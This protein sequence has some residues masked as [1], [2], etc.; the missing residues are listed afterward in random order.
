MILVDGKSGKP[1]LI[2]ALRICATGQHLE[3]SV[4]TQSKN[5]PGFVEFRS[6]K[7]KS[8]KKIGTPEALEKL[9]LVFLSKAE[10]PESSKICATGQHL[11]A[12]VFTQSKNPPGFMQFI[13]I[14]KKSMKKIGAPEAEK[15]LWSILRDK[16]F[17]EN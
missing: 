13:S 15:K 2:L 5:P 7:K 14:K 11:E 3:A 6:I 10:F 16:N 4:F 9:S 17:R 12:S 1:D 8:M